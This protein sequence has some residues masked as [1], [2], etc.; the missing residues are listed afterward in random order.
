M[1]LPVCTD[2]SS[3]AF[4]K[5]KA[6]FVG[7]LPIGLPGLLTSMSTSSYLAQDGVTPPAELLHDPVCARDHLGLS[8]DL[9]IPFIGP[10]VHRAGFL[11]DVAAGKPG[12]AKVRRACGLLL[13]ERQIWQKNN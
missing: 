13:N 9:A 12:G 7:S 5:G 11:L 1:W 6:A 8:D 2:E 10:D 3:R 4:V